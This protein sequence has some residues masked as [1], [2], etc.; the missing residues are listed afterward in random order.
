MPIIII[1][2]LHIN[3]LVNLMPFLFNA[4][5]FNFISL[6]FLVVA[7]NYIHIHKS[8]TQYPNIRESMYHR[9]NHLK[10]LMSYKLYRSC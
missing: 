9:S 10:Y 3:Y 4:K 6:L 8:T 7:K 5:R 1:K 2:K